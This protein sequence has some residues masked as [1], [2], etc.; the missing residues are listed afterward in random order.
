MNVEAKQVGTSLLVTQYH[1]LGYKLFGIF[2]IIFFLGGFPAL[3][4]HPD[5]VDASLTC[6]REAEAGMVCTA[7]TTW[8]GFAPGGAR[9]E[10]VTGARAAKGE[11]LLETARGT[12]RLDSY[13][14]GSLKSHAAAINAAI[15]QPGAGRVVLR[16]PIEWGWTAPLLAWLA[17]VLAMCLSM[18]FSTGSIT[19]FDAGLGLVRLRSEGLFR[20]HI[21]ELPLADVLNIYA[22]WEAAPSL[23]LVTPTK[24]I[25]ICWFSRFNSAKPQA[26]AG[27]VAKFILAWLDRNRQQHPARSTPAERDLALIADEDLAYLFG[28]A[29]LPIAVRRDGRSYLRMD[30]MGGDKWFQSNLREELEQPRQPP[31]NANS[32]ERAKYWAKRMIYRCHID[33]DRALAEAPPERQA[34]LAA[35]LPD[36]NEPYPRPDD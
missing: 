12:A 6:A 31:I 22:P 35:I 32:R 16:E 33:A 4:I 24:E 13:G 30:L 26:R 15:Q 17:V 25:P 18:L 20:A 7:R 19:V 34:T 23:Y 3:I 1:T 8:L 28:Y 9:F 5:I 27:Q 29:L 36:P 21:R 10:G 2:S 11:L 14:P